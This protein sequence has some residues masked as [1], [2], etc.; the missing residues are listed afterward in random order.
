[1]AKEN[2]TNVSRRESI[3]LNEHFMVATCIFIV[4]TGVASMVL[5]LK[6]QYPLAVF[7]ILTKLVTAVAMY[8]AFRFF[9]WDVAKGLMGGV[10]FCMMYQEAHLVLDQ[11]WGEQD[12]DIYLVT[13]VQG[14]LY[15]ASAGMAFL[16][17]IIIT[18]NHF[19]IN[20]ASHGN[21]KDVILNRI[22]IVFKFGVYLLLFA[23]NSRLDFPASILWMNA[24]QYLTDI[25]LLLL[26]VSVESQFDSFKL[27]HQEL[28]QQ[29]REGRKK[30]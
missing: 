18:I 20:Y 11:L 7:E 10:L 9:K 12:F 17:T 27:L 28:L 19:F 24:L 1:M 4:L 16:M 26:L 3:F 14:S 25:A 29:K 6:D 15:L 23:A 2:D 22:A 30:S 5:C 21:P 8:L 13:G